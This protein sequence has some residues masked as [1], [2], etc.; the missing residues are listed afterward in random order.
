MNWY[1]NGLKSDVGQNGWVQETVGSL[2]DGLTG[3]ANILGLG[4]VVKGMVRKITTATGSTQADAAFQS[5][6]SA[7]INSAIAKGN[8][9]LTELNDQLAKM[10]NI[11]NVSPAIKAFLGRKRADLQLQVKKQEQRNQEVSALANQAA[12]EAN[13]ASDINNSAGDYASGNVHN[14]Q[15]QAMGHAR[16]ALD[17]ASTVEKPVNE[18]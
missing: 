6:V 13:S 18:N 9:K 1:G 4:D 15:A 2:V 10:T 17:L 7:M 8:V 14:K 11:P 5:A 12:T 3:L 16:A